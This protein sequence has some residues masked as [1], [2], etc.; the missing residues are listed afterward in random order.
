MSAI[1]KMAVGYGL[2]LVGCGNAT[3]QDTTVVYTV[4]NGAGNTVDSLVLDT[5]DLPDISR[6]RCM[7]MGANK[8]LVD[9]GS[10]IKDRLK[11]LADIRERWQLLIDGEWNKERTGGVF[12]ASPIVEALA[13]MS[14]GLSIADVQIALAQYDDAKKQAI[15]SNPDL[16]SRAKEIEQARK[17]RDLTGA[18]D[19]L[20][21]QE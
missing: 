3:E 11:K 21:P 1:L 9:G 17:E 13:E 12:V 14:D 10:E 15:L 16:V 4:R 20:L 2:Q 6:H 19:A 7:L 18:L 8:K 5:D